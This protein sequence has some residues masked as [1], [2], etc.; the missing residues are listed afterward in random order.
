MA[1]QYLDLDGLK[2]YDELI[3]N[4]SDAKLNSAVTTLNSKINKKS[5]VTN[6]ENGS[7]DDSIQMT[8]KKNSGNTQSKATGV[9]AMALGLNTK[10]QADNSLTAGYQTETD[11]AATNSAAFGYGTKAQSNGEFVVGWFNETAANIFFQVGNGTSDSAR[12]SAFKVL[13]DGRAQVKGAPTADTDVVRLTDMNTKLK[14]YVP[15]TRTVNGKALSSN[16]TLGASDVGVTETVFPG[17]KKT[18][19]VTS[20]S[21]GDGLSGTVTESGSISHAVPT[22]AAAT[23]SGFYKVKTDK[24]GHIIGLTAV[25]KTDI[26][27]LGVPASDTNTQYILT[28][29]GLNIDLQASTDGK[30][31]T[32]QDSITV[33]YSL[34]A[35]SDGDGNNIANTY[36]KKAGGTIANDLVIKGNLTVNGTQTVNKTTNLDVK[37]A[38]IYSNA[39]GAT[40]ATNGGIG[41]KKNSTDIYGI[42]YDPATD[43]VK[44]GV[45]KA[46]ANGVFTFNDGEG[47]S[48]VATR[49]DS[50]ALTNAHLI[51]WNSAK[52]RF[53][54]SGHTYADIETLV[55][56][57][58]SKLANYVAIAGAQTVTGKKTFSGGIACSVAPTANTDV[59]RNEDVDSIPTASINALF[60]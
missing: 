27:A 16:I 33:P 47:E 23:A 4:Y 42:V 25:S 55:S 17:L 1:K 31:Y 49:A 11:S 18:G 6:L 57:V 48:P 21:G 13:S 39:D 58:N 24:F 5:D 54:D 56:N 46:D 3:K 50:S 20:V 10:A 36:L 52:N 59:L 35:E 7:A 30:T 41:I 19:T 8:D 22:G 37:N 44:L 2:T 45:G 43:S 14:S 32:T 53:E 38:M 26:T 28:V 29:N 15:T 60:G 40:L 51:I 9:K 12:S 34:K